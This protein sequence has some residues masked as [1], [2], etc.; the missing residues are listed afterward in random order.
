MRG[1]GKFLKKDLELSTDSRSKT[2]G[3]TEV[4]TE[5]DGE[6]S[7]GVTAIRTETSLDTT[8]GAQ[9]KD[10]QK[11][12]NEASLTVM[13]L[14]VTFAFLL[15]T[16]PLFVFYVVYL[17]KD[18]LASSKSYAEFAFTVYFTS[19]LWTSNAAVNFY[20]Y[21]LGGSKFRKDLKGIFSR[22]FGRNK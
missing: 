20:L 12:K 21:C 8:G 13:L 3:I 10:K 2:T 22:L 7:Q 4:K 6:S 5:T 11:S 15:L 18:N 14:L 17:I 16:T 9:Q 1:R 19:M